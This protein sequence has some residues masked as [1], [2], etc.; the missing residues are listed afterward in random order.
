MPKILHTMNL[1]FSNTKAVCIV[2]DKKVNR[3][4]NDILHT[5]ITTSFNIEERQ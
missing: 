5:N 2:V 3:Q 1:K 4:N